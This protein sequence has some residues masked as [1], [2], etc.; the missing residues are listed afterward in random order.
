[1][2]SSEA[3]TEDRV[4]AERREFGWRTVVY[5]FT[6]SRRH[7]HRRELDNEVIFLDWH[8]PW[9]FFLSVGTMLLSCAD[10]FLTLQLLNLGM[11]EANPI[12]QTA[13]DRGT[14]FFISLKLLMT[15]LGIFVLV[16][17]AKAHFLNRFRTGLFLTVFFSAYA[18]LVCYELVNLFRLL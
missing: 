10:A 11:I 14:E 5:G 17:V 9:L 15:A 7:A 18:C 12:M 8:H 6:L 13:L 3:T 4:R 16:F 1:M 2:E